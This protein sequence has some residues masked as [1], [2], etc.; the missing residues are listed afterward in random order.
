MSDIGLNLWPAFITLAAGLLAGLLGPL[1]AWRLLAGLPWLRRG[2]L[3]ALLTVGVAA[4][5]GSIAG[6]NQGGRELPLFAVAAA[7]LPQ[8]LVLPALL[9]FTRKH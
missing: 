2:L 9:F 1:L 8:L 6:F 4:I 3:A 7:F 5:A